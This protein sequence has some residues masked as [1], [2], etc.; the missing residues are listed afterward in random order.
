MNDVPVDLFRGFMTAFVPGMLLFPL[1][2]VLAVPTKVEE[3]D[4]RDAARKRQFALAIFTMLAIAV[5]GGLALIA[6]ETR[7]PV[8]EHSSRMAWVMFFPL[9]FGLGM[10][11]VIAKNPAWGGVC[12]PME[13]PGSPVRT[14]SLK[15]RHRENPIRTWHWVL[16]AVVSLV[17]LIL[18]ASR[19]AFS[20]GPDGPEASSARFRWVL[21]T[22]VYGF[23]SLMTLPIVPFSVRKSLVEPEPLDPSGSP[24]LEAMYRSER[25]KRILG[26]F[27]LLGVFQPLTLGALLNA[28]VWAPPASGRTLGII[29]AVVGTSIGLAGG[30][31]GTITT[32]RRVRIAEERARLE[33]ASKLR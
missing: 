4:A 6:R 33:A 19:G 28:M 3:H 1:I 24:E 10:P 18:L 11:A 2:F 16:M 21:I 7:L 29:G 26:L 27:W 14:A 8:F 9:W 30:V 25:R 15:P 23:C 22:G 17:P 5:W 32:I 12:R 31:I 13:S 20:F